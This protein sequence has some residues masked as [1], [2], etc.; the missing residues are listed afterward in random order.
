MKYTHAAEYGGIALGVLEDQNGALWFFAH[1]I[2]QPPGTPGSR[3]T[4]DKIP[5]KYTAQLEIGDIEKKFDV[6]LTNL[7]LNSDTVEFDDVDAANQATFAQITADN[8]Y[9]TIVSENGIYDVVNDADESVGHE[10]RQWVR[11][12]LSPAVRRGQIITTEHTP[13]GAVQDIS[14][15]AA[16]VG[17]VDVDA[18]TDPPHVTLVAAREDF[19][20]WCTVAEGT[21]DNT[22]HEQ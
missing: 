6:S 22:R 4:I 13:I 11:E 3:K 5:D 15:L 7:T 1:E 9:T 21:R 8:P 10:F 16:L 17:N 12:K 18:T 14:G 20:Y 2:T 19:F